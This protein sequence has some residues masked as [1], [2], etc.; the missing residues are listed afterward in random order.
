[1]S[2]VWRNRCDS[3]LENPSLKI[4]SYFLQLKS[5]EVYFPCNDTLRRQYQEKVT[6]K[7]PF[8]IHWVHRYLL[9]PYNG[10]GTIAGAWQTSCE[11]TVTWEVLQVL[12]AGLA[13]EVLHGHWGPHQELALQRSAGG[14]LL[15]NAEWCDLRRVDR[16]M[17]EEQVSKSR[18]RGKKLC[19]TSATC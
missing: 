13:R 14:T 6:V 4:K 9:A 2:L 18:S 19:L 11:G 10:T 16:R 8:N 12:R 15:G 3:E 5:L 17:K 7:N 1:M